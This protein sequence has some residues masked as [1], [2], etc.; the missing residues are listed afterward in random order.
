MARRMA[1]QTKR[2]M[3]RWMA[4][5][6]RFGRGE[7][8][9][10]PVGR[11]RLLDRH[12]QIARQVERSAQR[13]EPRRLVGPHVGEQREPPLLGRHVVRARVAAA[14]LGD[15]DHV[16]QVLRLGGFINSDPSF[17]EGPK[18]MNG[19]SDLMVAVLGDKGRHARSTVGVAVLPADAA[20]E[21][22]GIFEIA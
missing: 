13:L 19:A 16:K 9:R 11:V 22:E 5:A 4:R 12:G 10:E 20:V 3:A 2:H 1:R 21:V 7:P 8:L 15:L 14:A 17:L 18:V 6:G